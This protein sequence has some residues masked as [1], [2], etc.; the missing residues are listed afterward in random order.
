MEQVRFKSGM[1]ERPNIN[2]WA[3]TR[4]GLYPWQVSAVLALSCGHGQSYRD[5]GRPTDLDSVYSSCQE[6]RSGLVV[7]TAVSD[8]TDAAGA[9]M[10]SSRPATDTQDTSKNM[11]IFTSTNTCHLVQIN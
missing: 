9:G 10:P 5:S 1:E 2:W 8:R 11:E 7:D 6:P 4:G 3:R